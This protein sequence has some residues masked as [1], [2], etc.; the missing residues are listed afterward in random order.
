MI[1]DIGTAA[2]VIWKILKDKGETSVSRLG[3]TTGL[4]SSML[5]LALGWLAREDKI[6]FRRD[7]RTTLISL[8]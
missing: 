5:H 3:K 8:K 1:H 7:R 2:G 6:R 4:S